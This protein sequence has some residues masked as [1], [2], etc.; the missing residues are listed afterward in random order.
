VDLMSRV[1]T[2]RDADWWRF[3]VLAP[4]VVFPAE[5]TRL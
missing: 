3:A 4:L 5:L 1:G 2:F